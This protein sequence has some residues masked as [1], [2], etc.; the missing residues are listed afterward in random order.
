LTQYAQIKKGEIYQMKAPANAPEQLDRLALAN[1]IMTEEQITAY[2]RGDSDRGQGD[3]GAEVPPGYKR[4]GKCAH[5]KKFYLFNK[6]TASK[7]NTS[8]SCKECQKGNA[9]K[10][11]NKTKSK[12]NYKAYYQANKEAKQAQA[13]RYYEANKET[14]KE[15][16]A[17]YL[18]TRRGQK[19]MRKAHAKRRRTLASNKGV[20][21]TRLLVIERDGM[22]SGQPQPICYLCHNLIEDT[23]GNGLHIDHVIPVVEGG[24]DCFTN[25][26]STHKECNLRR[27]KDARELETEQVEHIQV[28]AQEFMDAY[29]EKFE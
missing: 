7:T 22:F 15:K 5:V 10:S 3:K 6:N 24:L 11:Y 20:P 28:L 2:L 12:R 4:C 26:A 25:V 13:R 16:H 21:Y 23:S 29:P 9:A 18:Q 17:A 1:I 19:V 27:E 8:G 14:L